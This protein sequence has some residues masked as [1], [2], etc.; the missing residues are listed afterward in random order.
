MGRYI[1]QVGAYHI[2]DSVE[3]KLGWRSR[4][5]KP[6]STCN[7]GRLRNSTPLILHPFF[8]CSADM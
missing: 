5:F 7:S 1:P 8:H 6:R 3:K 2:C 4:H